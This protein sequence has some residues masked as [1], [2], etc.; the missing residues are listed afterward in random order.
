MATPII[1]NHLAC[2]GASA[3][4]LKIPDYWIA[5]AKTDLHIAA[6]GASHFSQIYYGMTALVSWEK[7]GSKY[8]FNAGGTGGALDC[9]MY[10][11]DF[12]GLGIANSLEF[13]ANS[14]TNWTAWITATHD[15]IDDHPECN[16][17]WWNWCYGLNDS[18]TRVTDYCAAME[19][20]E[21]TYPSVK[22][23]Y[24]TGRTRAVGYTVDNTDDEVNNASLRAYCVAHNKWLYDFNDIEKYDPAGNYYG[25]K[26]VD[27]N[28]DYDKDGQKDGN[29]ATEWQTIHTGEWYNCESPHSQPLNANLKAYAA[30]YLWA[31]LAGWDG[32]VTEDRFIDWA[33]AGVWDNGVKGIPDT[34]GWTTINVKDAPYSATGNGSTDDTSAIQA[35]IDAA[36]ENYIIYFPAGTYRFTTLSCYMTDRI[37][38]KGAGAKN[39][40]LMCYGSGS[41][42]AINI[43]GGDDAVGPY[44]ISSGATKGSTSIVVSSTTGLSVGDIVTIYPD[45]PAGFC[46]DYGTVQAGVARLDIESTYPPQDEDYEGWSYNGATY[47]RTGH[48]SNCQWY[49][50]FGQLVEIDAI[51]GTTLTL[52]EPLYYD[53]SDSTPKLKKRGPFIETAGV[54]SMKVQFHSTAAAGTHLIRLWYAHNCWVKNCELYY[55]RSHGIY[56]RYSKS[57]EITKNYLHHGVSYAGSMSYLISFADYNSDHLVYDNIVRHGRHHIVF[58]GGGQG[59]VIGYNYSLDTQGDTEGWLFSDLGNHGRH[60]YMNLW[61]GNDAGGLEFDSIHGS[62]SHNI[63]LRN[64][65]TGKGVNDEAP[66]G[67]TAA[68]I[69][70]KV[71]KNSIYHSFVGNVLGYDGAAT[72]GYDYENYEQYDYDRH[73]IYF[74]ATGD[75]ASLISD[76]PE[77][78]FPWSMPAATRIM[79][80]NYDYADEEIKWDTDYPDHTIVDSLYLSEK[81][82][83]FGT[84]TWPPIGP[85]VSGYVTDIPAKARYEAFVASEDVDDLFADQDETPSTGTYTIGIVP[86]SKTV[87]KGASAVYDVTINA[88][89]G[90][91]DNVTLGVT[92]LPGGVTPTFADNPLGPDATTTL[93]IPTSA[94]DVQTYSLKVTG[95]A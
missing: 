48:S 87:S 65:F 13:D 32:V 19:T 4:L 34:S 46:S 8:S 15:Y 7:G 41:S 67:Y 17:I 81:P 36:G 78:E 77:F 3:S 53:Y 89:E 28:C 11:G 10:V 76:N 72:D 23:V 31:R 70:M 64:T 83:W 27:E 42:P 54:E 63:V 33:D 82:S 43:A 16:V 29:W 95:E 84:Y 75:T 30:W 35:A 85:D 52:V 50:G 18:P 73:M 94:L 60:Q 12:G 45:I 79:H 47:P 25:D 55:T 24:A 86:S 92:G 80:G 51:N 61:E 66:E 21:A 2:S 93:T 38:L 22:F 9:R 62:S 1:V 69:C 71:A 39:T 20:L 40:I 56:T 91:T 44:T 58:E 74:G 90:F 26:D 6:G 5:K 49:D 59:C 37:L 57:C 14:N 88:G 68:R